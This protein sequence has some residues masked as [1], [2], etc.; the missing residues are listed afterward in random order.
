MD[1]RALTGG[2]VVGRGSAH[3]LQRA[4]SVLGN[5]RDATLT[6]T[7]PEVPEVIILIGLQGS[8]KSTFYR[9]R[10]DQSHFHLSKD[11]FKNNSHPQRRQILLC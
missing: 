8:G 1:S 9:S 4:V 7:S 2:L 10:F 11:L 3:L 5:S 6:D